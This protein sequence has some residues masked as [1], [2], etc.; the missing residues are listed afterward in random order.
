M[1]CILLRRKA[2]IKDPWELITSPN[3]LST[4]V[5]PNKSKIIFTTF[6]LS[7]LIS[8]LISILLERKKN[9]VFSTND[10]IIS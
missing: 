5:F 9:I 4:P 7:L 1:T 2:R 10:L 8:S 3:L 6:F